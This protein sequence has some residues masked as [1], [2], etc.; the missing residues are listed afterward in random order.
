MKISRDLEDAWENVR[1][2]KTTANYMICGISGD[3]KSAELRHKGTAGLDEFVSKLSDNEVLFGGLRCRAVDDR[4]TM[5]S[6]R[7]KFIFVSWLGPKLGAVQRARAGT[8]RFEFVK[9]FGGAH[10]ALQT[11][12]KS[13]FEQANLV[14][15]LQSSTGAHKPTGYEFEGNDAQEGLVARD[16]G[17]E[18]KAKSSSP[19][20]A[21]PQARSESNSPPPSSSGG[22]TNIAQLWEEIRDGKSSLNWVMLSYDGKDPKTAALHDKGVT[23]LSD[24]V[25]KLPDDKVLFCGLRCRAIDDRGTVVS[26]RNKFIFVA[27][28]GPSVKPMQRAKVSTH[29]AVFEKLL[30]GTHVQYQTGDKDD[31]T[32]KELEHKLQASTGAHKPTGYEF[33]GNDAQEGLVARDDGV[34]AK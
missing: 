32:E 14:Q 24:V 33:E 11:S 23:G 34:E 30:S 2:D 21:S 16:D 17:V 1:D 29:K 22:S 10:I 25:S 27:W 3:S 18:A 13:D 12:D 6:V 28:V 19:A 9:L 7:S 8:L 20:P 31:L 4:G 26:V 15:M 5:K